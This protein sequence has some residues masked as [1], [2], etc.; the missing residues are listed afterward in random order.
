MRFRR[1]DLKNRGAM[2]QEVQLTLCK[3]EILRFAASFLSS[4]DLKK[5]PRQLY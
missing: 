2:C 3:Y 5:V 1:P 4:K